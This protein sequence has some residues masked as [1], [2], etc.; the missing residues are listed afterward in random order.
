MRRANTGESLARR[1]LTN[2]R[3]HAHFAQTEGLPLSL[4]CMSNGRARYT[5]GRGEFCVDDRGF[6]IVN[7]GQP[8]TI[9][10]ASPTRV[11]SFICW[12]PAG[13]AEEVA[14]TIEAP[15]SLQLDAPDERSGSPVEFFTRYISSDADVMPR[16]RAILR[17]YKS[18]DTLED[19]WLE[20]RLRDLLAAMLRSERGAAH[21]IASISAERP[22]TRAELWRRL[23]H[24]RD[25]IHANSSGDVS[26]TN[27]ARAACLSPYHFL[28]SFKE[29]FG[30]TPHQFLT[31]CRI[32]RAKFLLERTDIPVTDICLDAGFL[33]LGSF[34]TLFHRAT[35]MPPRAWRALHASGGAKNSNIREVFLTC[36]G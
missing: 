7:E 18:A 4:K 35:G 16:A 27:A 14:R 28:R 25:F 32:E 34:S 8:Y 13:W 21:G 12:F 9:E 29:A 15:A 3:G 1:T 23:H 20:E 26:L 17:A 11:E 22:S 5:V 30:I 36:R 24:G 6:M 10:I 31:R 33:S 2:G 19:S